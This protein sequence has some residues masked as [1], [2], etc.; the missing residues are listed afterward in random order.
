MRALFGIMLLGALIALS[1]C[2]FVPH[3]IF[4]D[5]KPV[6]ATNNATE[7][8]SDGLLKRGERVVYA[9]QIPA[10]L[11]R[12]RA[13]LYLEVEALNPAARIEVTARDLLGRVYAHSYSPE[14]FFFA[15]AVSRTALVATG[16]LSL[17]TQAIEPTVACRGPCVLQPA[18][19]MPIYL[20]IINRGFSET[21]YNLYAFRDVYWDVNEPGNDA[22]SGAVEI[23]AGRAAQGAL[24]T[25]GDVDFFVTAG[26]VSRVH[27]AGTMT[28]EI[29]PT[30]VLSDFVT[31][32]RIATITA[33]ANADISPPRRVLIRVYSGNDLAGPSGSSFYEI[34]T[35][36]P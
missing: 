4:P 29:E 34:T 19:V 9:V 23:P 16:E 12:E 36:A 3:P 33:G 28:V 25:L 15:P 30:A 17:T 26:P 24:E 18:P 35:T 22:E 7:V 21:R 13:L 11:V 27:L 32:A 6:T 31:G 8:V 2:Q 5:A 14:Y 20:E 1:A 10:A